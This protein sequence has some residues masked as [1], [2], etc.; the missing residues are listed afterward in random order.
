MLRSRTSPL[1][2]PDYRDGV[3]TLVFETPLSADEVLGRLRELHK[4]TYAIGGK[5]APLYEGSIFG[6]RFRLGVTYGP[7][8]AE[9]QFAGL[10]EPIEGGSRITLTEKLID[11][12][13]YILVGA[14]PM[15]VIV[16][17]V[18]GIFEVISN[19]DFGPLIALIILIAMYIVAMKY[20][21]KNF[22][23][24]FAEQAMN[25]ARW[26]NARPVTKEPATV[27]E[28]DTGAESPASVAYFVQDTVRAIHAAR[29]W[30][31]PRGFRVLKELLY[32]GER[33]AEAIRAAV[34]ARDL[35][36]LDRLPSMDAREDIARL[37][38]VED[39]DPF[40]RLLLIVDPIELYDNPHVARDFGSVDLRAADLAEA[41]KYIVPAVMRRKKGYRARGR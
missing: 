11:S 2:T 34:E 36:R 12:Q 16:F 33:T 20:Q 23:K 39:A 19:R 3:C 38:L 15:G 21:R 10:I 13:V 5:K 40:D 4:G 30:S 41:R 14:V 18:L 7:R 6:R 24:R 22:P 31:Q 8:A 9:P 17:L 28:N 35:S 26:L 37:V 25:L 27:A 29:P 1:P 32:E